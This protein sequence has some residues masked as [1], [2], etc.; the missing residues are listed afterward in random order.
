MT[1]QYRHHLARLTVGTSALV[2]WALAASAGAQ[3]PAPPQLD[4]RAN[5]E[6]PTE[7][8]TDL[9]FQ[10]G[11]QLQSGNTQSYAINGGVVY[12]LVRNRHA[13][14][15]DSIAAWGAAAPS[16]GGNVQRTARNWN[17]RWRYDYYVTRMDALYVAQ[18]HRWDTFAGLYTRLQNQ[19]GYLRNFLKNDS[20]HLWGEVGYDLTWDSL[21]T[22]DPTTMVRTNGTAI[23]HAAR[24]FVGDDSQ[25]NEHVKLRTGAEALFNFQDANDIRVNAY[26]GVTT[27]FTEHFKLEIMFTVLFDNV[28]VP[29]NLPTDTTTLISLIYDAI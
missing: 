20:H 7:D 29:G 15:L 10:F 17:S 16:D 21:F 11:T 22:I 14:H 5:Q 25:F 4:A 6:R 27:S 23:V 12:D 18:R 8:T 19:A 26:L 3:P 13:F 2:F 28:P 1:V 9:K 24:V